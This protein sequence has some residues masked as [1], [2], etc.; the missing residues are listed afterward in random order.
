MKLNKE[1]WK[2]KYRLEDTP[3]DAGSATTPITTFIDGL[4]D[5]NLKI[6]IPG[7]GN[8]HEF[9]YLYNKGFKNIY[10]L[11]ITEEPL[12]NIKRKLP[13]LPEKYLILQDFFQLTGSFDLILEQTFFCALAP[14]LRPLYAKKINEILTQKGQLAGVL[15]DFPLTESGP[16]YGGDISEYI[17]LFEPFFKIKTLE[18]CYNSIKP[19]KDKEIF[20]HFYK[21]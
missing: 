8:G 5:K 6:L 4:E 19:R 14:D 20:I 21:K 7:V 10:A 17:R 12:V 15:F 3:W 2:E 1:F 18:R 9:E 16:P 13:E 11:D